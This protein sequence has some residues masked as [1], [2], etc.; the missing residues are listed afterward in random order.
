MTQ[1]HNDPNHIDHGACAYVC[2]TKCRFV[3]FEHD[4]ELIE[5]LEAIG[6]DDIG[7]RACPADKTP[8]CGRT[9]CFGG[10]WVPDPLFNVLKLRGMPGGGDGSNR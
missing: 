10:Y 4:T 1:T 3:G 9:R 6:M 7:C 2:D 5:Y 8:E